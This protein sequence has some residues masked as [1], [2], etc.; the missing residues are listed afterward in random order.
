MFRSGG[1][2]AL[3]DDLAIASAQPGHQTGRRRQIQDRKSVSQ[4]DKPGG[5]GPVL[6]LPPPAK[7][8]QQVKSQLRQ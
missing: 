6:A 8:G 3:P 2:G 1:I 7:C 4:A 5:E